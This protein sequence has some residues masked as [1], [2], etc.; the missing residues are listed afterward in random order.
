MY[1]TIPLTPHTLAA[2]RIHN[3]Y[4]VP[5]TFYVCLLQPGSLYYFFLNTED[6][7]RLP[8]TASGPFEAFS[9]RQSL[10]L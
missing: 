1:T 10:S 5:W 7:G 6:G 8:F 3:L 9:V 4:V 2:F